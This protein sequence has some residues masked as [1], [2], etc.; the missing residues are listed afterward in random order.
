MSNSNK[1]EFPLS[2]DVSQWIKALWAPWTNW[3]G[4]LGFLNI[5]I[6][7]TAAPEIEQQIVNNVASY[8]SQIGR[9]ADVLD[10]LIAKEISEAGKSIAPEE[11]AA[12]AAFAAFRDQFA[13]IKEA[14]GTIPPATAPDPGDGALSARARPRRSGSGR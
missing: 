6:G 14:R 12:F 2:G 8:G 11:M 4:Q 3:M 7:A 5:N 10:I 13:K 1:V 9:M